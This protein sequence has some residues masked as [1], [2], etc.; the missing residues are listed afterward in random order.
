MISKPKILENPNC[1]FDKETEKGRI[2]SS[3]L[4]LS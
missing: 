2:S 4:G 3:E 1:L